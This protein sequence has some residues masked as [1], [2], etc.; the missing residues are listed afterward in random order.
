M[1]K[2]LKEKIV[3][4]KTPKSA[5]K[6]YGEWWSFKESEPETLRYAI[7]HVTKYLVNHVAKN[8]APDEIEWIIRLASTDYIGS[9][10]DKP[11]RDIYPDH[12]STIG[13]KAWYKKA[14]KSTEVDDD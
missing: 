5:G 7:N 10:L 9:P 14:R 6:Q 1:S 8:G 4:L 11:N 2:E 3:E 13:W 12:D